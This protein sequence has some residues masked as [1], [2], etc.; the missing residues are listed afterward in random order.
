MMNEAIR[1][2]QQISP[3]ELRQNISHLQKQARDVRK[4]TEAGKQGQAA[5]RYRGRTEDWELRCIKCTEL[6]CLA[7]DIRQIQQSHHVI[8]DDTINE[9]VIIE[10]HPNPKNYG[11]FKKT[12][13]IF[14]HNCR[15]DWGIRA[16]YKGSRFCVIKIDS[17]VITNLMNGVRDTC[18]KW[19]NAPFPV[20]PLTPDELSGFAANASLPDVE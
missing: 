7:R 5:T 15:Y 17:F 9:R 8:L 18:K 20:S 2:V 19:K 13:K 4:M 3:D 12:D 10:S 11:D 16:I 6:C 1:L 14:C